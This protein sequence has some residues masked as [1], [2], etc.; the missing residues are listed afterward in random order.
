[1]TTK[2][3]DLSAVERPWDPVATTAAEVAQKLDVDPANG[4][5]AGE[6]AKRL[7]SNGPNRLTAARRNRPGGPSSVQYE[8]FMQVILLGAAL[9][10]QLV[11]RKQKTHGSSSPD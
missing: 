6:A 2:D 1:M 8:G 11:T 4:L 5:S 10:N 9:V 7:A 3:A